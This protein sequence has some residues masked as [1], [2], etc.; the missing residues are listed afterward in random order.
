MLFWFHLS[1][2][3]ILYHWLLDSLSFR[4][5]VEDLSVIWHKGVQDVGNVFRSLGSGWP[6]PFRTFS[7]W[8]SRLQWWSHSRGQSYTDIVEME[9]DTQPQTTRGNLPQTT[10]TTHTRFSI[11]VGASASGAQALVGV[12]HNIY[13]DWV[14]QISM[15]K[16]KLIAC[17]Y[18]LREEIHQPSPTDRPHLPPPGFMAFSEAI[19]R[20]G[21]SLP[22]H[23]F[24]EAVL[25]YFNVA[26]CKFTLN[27]FYI[28]MAFFIVFTEACLV[29]P[30][31][32][33]FAYI[34]GIK[35]LMKHKGFWY[36]TRQGLDVKG[37][38]GL[39]SNIGQWKG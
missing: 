3:S 19:M 32:N 31:V 18:R 5:L 14:S 24:I 20:G 30:T 35:A 12:S 9:R 27:S 6:Q 29:E 22:L 38:V 34:F 37:I 23:P 26:P 8:G 39:C 17:Q 16:L 11:S 13:R 15:K 2:N 36:T 21:G 10:H 4:C 25:Q 33:E 7:W 28:I 1:L